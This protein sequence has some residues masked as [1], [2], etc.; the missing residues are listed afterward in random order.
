MG[1]SIIADDSGTV[2]GSCIAWLLHQIASR[3]FDIKT[4]LQPLYKLPSPVYVPTT[5]SQC[6]ALLLPTT[7]EKERLQPDSL[8]RMV[9]RAVW[10]N[11]KLLLGCAL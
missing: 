8:Q 4:N 9:W 10:T 11:G 2:V 6:H 5:S 1:S 3:T 7:K